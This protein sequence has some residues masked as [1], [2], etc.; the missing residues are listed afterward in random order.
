M[1]LTSIVRPLVQHQEVKAQLEECKRERASLETTQKEASLSAERAEAAAEE[2]RREA[3]QAL[4]SAAAL[5]DNIQQADAVAAAAAHVEVRHLRT[6][7]PE[8]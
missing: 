3:S 1:I 2:A 6:L 7:P 5:R 8:T 4:A